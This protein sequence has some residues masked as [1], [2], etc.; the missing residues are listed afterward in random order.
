MA[1]NPDFS[2]LQPSCTDCSSTYTIK[3]AVKPWFNALVKLTSFDQAHLGLIQVSV[4]S[5]HHE[6]Y[7]MGSTPR[8]SDP[9]PLGFTGPRVSRRLQVSSRSPRRAQQLVQVMLGH[10]GLLH[11]GQAG[12]MVVGHHQQVMSWVNDGW[13]WWFW[14]LIMSWF[15]LILRIDYELWVGSCW[16]GCCELILMI[17]LDLGELSWWC[18]L[19]LDFGG[20][21]GGQPGSKGKLWLIMLVLVV[22]IDGRVV[23]ECWRFDDWVVIIGACCTNV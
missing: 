16:F 19:M 15:M 6:F 8:S 18:I 1:F 13:F 9:Q 23:G 3:S 17:L 12:A 4:Q 11:G 2:A 20:W 22:D 14:W 7:P 10:L 5:L 21:M